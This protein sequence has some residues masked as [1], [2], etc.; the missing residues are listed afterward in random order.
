MVDS[1]L[2]GSEQPGDEGRRAKR[3]TSLTDTLKTVA[4]LIV[5]VVAGVLVTIIATAAISKN[6]QTALTVATATTGIIG[7]VAGAYLGMK[8]GNDRA[9]AAGTAQQ[10]EAAK[11][12][13]YAL[14]IPDG[15]AETARN[16]AEAAVREVRKTRK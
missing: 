14:H 7:S 6:S 12:Q 8:T 3:G 4:G 10:E 11:A 2:T 9:D 15:K 1:G 13:V 5:V 16:E